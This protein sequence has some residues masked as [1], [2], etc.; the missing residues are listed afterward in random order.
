VSGA[1]AARLAWGMWAV[2]LVAI[3]AFILLDSDGAGLASLVSGAVF[4]LAFSTTGALVVGRHPRNPVGWLLSSTALAFT[5]G[6]LAVAVSEHAVRTQQLDGPLVAAAA[7]V[8]SWVWMAGIGPAATFLLLLF[9]DGHLP[10]PRWRPVAWLAGA[11]VGSAVVGLAFSPG[12]IEDTPVANPLGVP[13]AGALLDAVAAA[14]LAA[15]FVSILLSCAS[16]VVRYR[17]APTDQRQQLKWVAY[18]LPVV[19]LS[20]I[21]S[22]VLE[23]VS[24]SDAAVD[25]A[26]T[27]VAAGLTV[28]PVSI[29]VAMLRYRLYDLDL[30]VNRTL[31]YGLL[32]AALAAVYLMSVLVL[33]L[34]LSPLT[35]RSDLAVAASTLAVAGLFRPARARMQAVVDRRFFRRR[36]DAAR[37]LDEFGSRLRHEVD[38]EAVGTDLR[39]TVRSTVQPASVSLWLRGAR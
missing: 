4:I 20:L 24:S 33:Q 21:A 31:V 1:L 28:V 27:L 13:G 15:L 8:G 10:S 36:Y 32:T 25:L 5:T 18:A 29:G 39:A 2:G 19:V 35:D 17:A 26:N 7:W 34:V 23:F 22:I 38:L 3:G 30:V 11:A 12:P 14:G 37:T 9:P 16:L 6:G